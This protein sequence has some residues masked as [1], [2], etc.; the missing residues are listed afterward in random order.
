MQQAW[1]KGGKKAPRTSYIADV[2]S[3]VATVGDIC[4]PL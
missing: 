2:M 3:F 4:V 1:F